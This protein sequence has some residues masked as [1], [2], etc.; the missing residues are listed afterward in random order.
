[1]LCSNA[2]TTRTVQAINT[3]MT[4]MEVSFES[5]SISKLS[6]HLPVFETDCE[7]CAE[8]DLTCYFNTDTGEYQAAS[9]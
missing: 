5:L 7:D 9:W 2:T 6:G 4:S 1:M 3:T 8:Y